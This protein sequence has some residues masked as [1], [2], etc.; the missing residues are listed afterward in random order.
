ME[1][2]PSTAEPKAKASYLVVAEKIRAMALDGTLP[3]GHRLPS[4]SE[5]C[6]V[7]GVSRTTLREAL[8]ILS[9]ERLITTKRGVNGGSIISPLEPETLA[10]LLQTSIGH[11]AASENCNVQELL[12]ARELLEVPAAR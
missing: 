5:L 12:E 3:I 9:T 2:T 1:P 7:F 6:D 4:E 11:L 8:R 10:S